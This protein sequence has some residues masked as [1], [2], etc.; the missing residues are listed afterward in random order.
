[1]RH[2]PT[3]RVC[4]AIVDLNGDGL[5][6]I[7]EVNHMAKQS[8]FAEICRHD[9]HYLP[10][11][12]G[13][14]FV[15]EQDRLFSNHGDG[16]FADITE[17]SGIVAPL[18]FG[19]GIVAA[20]FSNRGQIDV[21]VANDGYANFYFV[22][23]TKQPGGRVELSERAVASGVA[24]DP[25]GAPQACMGV[26]SADADG[27]GLIDLFVT[28]YFNEANAFYRQTGAEFFVDNTRSA[29]LYMPSYTLL[30][31]GTQFIDGEL[32][33]L[34]DLIITN[35]D[36]ED[37]TAVGRPYRQRPQYFKNLG[38]AKFSEVATASLGPFFEGAYLGRGLSRLDWN[39]DGLEDCVISHLDSPTALL[40]NRTQ[41][42]GNF[43]AV[44]L[45]GVASARDAIGASVTVRCGEESWI[46][47]L[48]AGDGF[49]ASN[50]RELVF[51]LGKHEQVDT[52]TI[53]WPSGRSDE[54]T[55]LA[56]GNEIMCVEGR[57]QYVILPR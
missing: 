34:R 46:Q 48:T 6:E 2:Q 17:D 55:N 14:K 19:L 15:P 40:T 39:R 29:A 53:R 47:S 43:L 45:R 50:E 12:Q 30:G 33:G 25:N 49:M 5:P 22:N 8:V 56:V 57:S 32:D 1:M 41:N 37:F 36:V 42:V 7:Y 13:L 10:C 26:A 51:G 4:A 52:L 20:D 3:W 27:D 11:Q 54:F 28:N 31:F 18:G 16:T 23:Q 38:G 21:F 44:Q 35:G 24:F 9:S